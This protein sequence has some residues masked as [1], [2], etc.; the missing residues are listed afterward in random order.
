[1]G[2]ETL[3]E[4]SEATDQAPERVRIVPRMEFD[5]EAL[6]QLTE[7]EEPPHRTL[8]PD[9]QG[10]KVRY[11]FGDASGAGFGMSGWTPGDEKVEVDFGAWQPDKMKGSS[12]NFR[13]LANIVMKV[14]QMASEGRLNSLAEV[15]IFT[16]N[17]HAESAFYRG[18]AKSPEVLRLMFRLHKILM[19]GEAFVHVVWVSGKRMIA[20]GTDGLSRSDLTN[21]V[22]RHLRKERY[23]SLWRFNY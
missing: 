11:F 23:A 2:S 14:E 13:E 22:M 15:F 1:M 21:G 19:V 18:T 17:M 16:D 5:V 9:K 7:S 3:D 8:R 4:L 6:E 20:Q 10:A 12:S